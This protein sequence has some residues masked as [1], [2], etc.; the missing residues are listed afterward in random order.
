MQQGA[1]LALYITGSHCEREGGVLIFRHRLGADGAL[2]DRKAPL[3][4]DMNST[5]AGHC[6]ETLSGQRLPMHAQTSMLKVGH[7]CR[8]S[9]SPVRHVAGRLAASSGCRQQEVA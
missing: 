8:M 7:N 3:T 5:V 4:K 6:Q 1:F 2:A 9:F